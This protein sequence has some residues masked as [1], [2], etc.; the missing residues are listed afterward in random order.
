MPLRELE[1]SHMGNEQVG[2]KHVSGRGG[3]GWA[4][5]T[6]GLEPDLAVT[7]PWEVVQCWA[8]DASGPP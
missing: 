5:E 8:E 3:W 6:Q 2:D 4:R 1:M 7:R